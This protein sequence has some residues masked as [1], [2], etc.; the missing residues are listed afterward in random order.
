MKIKPKHILYGGD[1]NPE[2]WLEE[3]DILKKDIEY[4]KAAGINTVTLGVFSW[5]ML[6]PEEGNYQLDWLE[7]IIERLY[8]NGISTILATPSGARPKWLADSYPEVLRVADNRVRNLFGGR[9][10]HCFTSPVYR[11][12]VRRINTKL[13]ERFAQHPAVL[14][15]HISNEY[16]GECHCPLCQ[17]EFRRFLEKKY[18]NIDALNKSWCT[19]FWSHIYQSFE[20]VESPSSIGE[21]EVH[22]LTLDWKRFVTMQTA[23]F[24]KWEIKALRDVGAMQPTTVNLMYDYDGLNYDRL[25]EC[26][27]VIS[28]DS[29]P[30][31]HKQKDI[32]AAQ[33]NGMQHD[34]M[35]SLKHAPYLLMESCPTGTNWQ[36][37]SKLKRPGLLSAASFQAIAHGSDSVLYFQI[38]QS[39]GSSEKFH[40]AVID[41]YGGTN[42]R[43]FQ[44]VS[45][46]GSE[47]EQL[48]ELIGSDV[49]AEAAVIYDVENRW[50][51]EDAKGPRNDGMYYREAVAK[52]YRALKKLGLNID[53][54]SAEQ[55]ISSYR[56]VAVPMLYLLRAGIEERLERFVREGGCVLVTYWSGIVDEN[57]C[58]YLR[59]TPHGLTEVLGLRRTETDSLYEE[60]SNTMLPLGDGPVQRAYSCSHLCE[61]IEVHSAEPFMVYEKEFY[62]GMPVATRNRYQKGMAYYVGADAEQGFY[63]ELYAAIVKE[64]GLSR[65]VPG[66]IPEGI[67][68]NSR[69]SETAKYL[70]VQNFQNDTVDISGMGL[71]AELMYGNSLEK[72]RAYETIIVKITNNK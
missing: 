14:L 18:G 47:L 57:D 67:E 56:L 61:L 20:Q 25:A 68:V 28:W 4:M 48:T 27:D 16:G 52:S 70:F 60:E 29:Y 6:E 19:A 44:E 37:V 72:L 23:D 50:A 15:W 8:D 36:G 7:T 54:I 43:V 2:Q 66:I 1:Y 26:V 49:K 10:N 46:I 40:G 62:Q 71:C 59:E 30:V 65:C 45:K 64:C 53:V 63:D 17:Q 51:I 22:G 13:G 32:L 42:T 21:R 33:D 58:C 34:Y 12:K 39:R 31:W 35:R 9:H 55:D 5:S 38:R 69:S 24:A 3:P 11:E 41:H